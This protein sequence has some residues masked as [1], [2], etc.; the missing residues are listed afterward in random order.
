MDILHLVGARTKLKTNPPQKVTIFQDTY[1]YGLLLAWLKKS[2][3]VGT[4]LEDFIK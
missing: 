3:K 4:Q 2:K 1:V